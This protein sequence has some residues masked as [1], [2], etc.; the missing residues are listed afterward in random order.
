MRCRYCGTDRNLLT[1]PYRD[2]DGFVSDELVDLCH[3]CVETSEERRV[4]RKEWNHYHPDE[5]CPEVEL[6]QPAP[7]IWPQKED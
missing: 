4:A 3:G 2:E 7:R 1:E 6:P 5:P